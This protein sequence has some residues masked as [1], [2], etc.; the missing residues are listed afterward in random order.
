METQF[1]PILRFA[2]SPILPSTHYAAQRL[3]AIGRGFIQRQKTR[4]FLAAQRI[5]SVFRAYQYRQRYQHMRKQAIMIQN[6]FRSVVSCSR[7][8]DKDLTRFGPRPGVLIKLL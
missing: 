6:V 7:F 4:R 8:S 1:L 3:Q 5:G 2:K